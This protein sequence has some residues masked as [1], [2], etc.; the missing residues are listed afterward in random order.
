MMMPPQQ[1]FL[2]EK[3]FTNLAGVVGT[4][5][6]EEK[7]S[8]LLALGSTWHSHAR[9]GAA[10]PFNRQ[11]TGGPGDIYPNVTLPFHL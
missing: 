2:Y 10:G 4:M 1:I 9:L 7:W 11:F 6:R 5:P 3:P 8:P